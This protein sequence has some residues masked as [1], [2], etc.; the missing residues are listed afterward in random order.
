MVWVC[1]PSHN[2]PL[3]L[4]LPHFVPWVL[5]SS[6]Y[7]TLPQ[8]F[9]CLILSYHHW[10]PSWMTTSSRFFWICPPSLTRLTCCLFP[11]F[12]QVHGC[13]LLLQRV[14]V[15]I[16]TLPNFRLP[17]SVGVA[18]AFLMVH[19]AHC[20]LRLPWTHLAIML[21]PA[22][23]V[24]MW[25][26]TTTNCVMSLWSPV[27]KLIWVS[28]WKWVTNLTN[29]SHTRLADL[30][31]PNWVLGKPAALTCLSHLCLIILQVFWKRL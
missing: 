16:F 21:L 31:F 22:K 27:G 19:A 28:R 7:I 18:W 20:A 17:L 29:H 1:V 3:Q 13:L 23:G 14:L 5:A 26:P 25:F 12:M 10:P 4:T 30:L 6:L 2:T 8:Q 15:S 24:V 11:P 9:K